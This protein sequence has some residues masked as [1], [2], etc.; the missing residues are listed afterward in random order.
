MQPI[1]VTIADKLLNTVYNSVKAVA[2]PRFKVD[3]SISV[4]KFKTTIEKGYTLNWTIGG[5]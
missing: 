3:D 4:N 2:L 1:N 5:V